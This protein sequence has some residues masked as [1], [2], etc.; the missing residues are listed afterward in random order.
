MVRE[1][2]LLSRVKGTDNQVIKKKG[3]RAQAF[4]RATA[5]VYTRHKQKKR[6]KKKQAKKRGLGGESGAT[7]GVG[8]GTYRT[9]GHSQFLRSPC[10]GER[11]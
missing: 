2:G 3:E 7:H 6:E 11:P 1:G 4:V 10:E 9:A 8:W 5:S